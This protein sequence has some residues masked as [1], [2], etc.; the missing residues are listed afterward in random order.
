MT[1]WITDGWSKRRKRLRQSLNRQQG[2]S[3]YP[4]GFTDL[5]GWQLSQAS[6]LPPCCVLKRQ[7]FQL[8]LER[9][10]PQQ[11]KASGMSAILKTQTLN[12]KRKV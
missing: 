9:L 2:K 10:V 5:R 3:A 11:T 8:C 1:L 6:K 12:E 4:T 7:T